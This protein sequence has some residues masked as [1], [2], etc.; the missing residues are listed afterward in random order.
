MKE[1]GVDAVRRALTYASSLALN[2]NAPNV[3]LEIL[4]GVTQVNYV[5]VRNLKV[6]T[7]ITYQYPRISNVRFDYMYINFL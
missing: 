7:W 3:A 1:V 2:Q 4:S 6:C 5:T